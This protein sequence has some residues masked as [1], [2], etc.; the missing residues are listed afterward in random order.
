MIVDSTIRSERKISLLFSRYWGWILPPLVL[1]VLPL[2]FRSGFALSLLN[3]ILIAAILAIS[4]NMLFGQS[5][6]LSFGHAIFFGLGGFFAIHALRIFGDEAISFP[7][8]LLPLIGAAGGL[9]FGLIFGSISTKKA[10]VTFA[11]ITIGLGELV[12]AAAMIPNPFFGGEEGISADRVI[13]PRLFGVDFGPQI[14]IYYLIAAWTFLSIILMYAFSRTPMGRMS[15][16]VRDNPERAQ[17][18]G[19]NPQRVRWIAFSLSGLFAGIAGSL[20]AL[21]YEIVTFETVSLHQS[22]G[23][24]FMA[25]LGGIRHFFGPILGAVLYTVLALMLSD[26]TEAWFLYYGI[27]F[28]IFV[29]YVPGGMANILAI[30]WPVFK[31]GLLHK[32]IRPYVIAIVPGVV[33]VVGGIAFIEISYTVSFATA[34]EETLMS[35]FGI[36]FNAAAPWPWLIS[37]MLIGIGLYFFRRSFPIVASRW[38]EIHQEIKERMA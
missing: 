17:F 32:L 25:Y 30:H 20:Y 34:G 6:L 19:Y 21:N 14:E 36:H 2:I 37:I 22:V 5:G 23:M 18:V 31:T 8:F 35:L 38:E 12:H 33:L 1:I 15:N 27:F 29:M 26:Y 16:A 10:G 11:L 4:L 7:V 13:G 24:I 9:F 3:S 28:I